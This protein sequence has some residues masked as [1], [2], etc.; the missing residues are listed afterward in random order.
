MDFANSD[1]PQSDRLVRNPLLQRCLSLQ[2]SLDF[3]GEQVKKRLPG[4]LAWATLHLRVASLAFALTLS[5]AQRPGAAG[6]DFRPESLQTL[7]GLVKWFMDMMSLIIGDLFDLA[8]ECRGRTNDLA[9]VR[10]KML[11]SNTPALI[12]TLASAP[13]AFL[14]YNCRSLKGLE[15]STGKALQAGNMVDEDARTT[16]RSF[17]VPIESCAIK[18]SQFE[19]IMTDI[20]GTVRAAYHNV[21]E[22]ERAA[23][24]RVLFVNNEIPAIFAAP[25]ERLLSVTLPQLW[26]E[27]NVSA[28]FF[29]DVSWLGFHDDIETLNYQKKHRVDAVRKVLL[30]PVRLR[31][32][33]RC[34]SIVD[35]AVMS[36]TPVFWLNNF[37]RMCLCGT[38][39][40]H[41][42]SEG[43]DG[44]QGHS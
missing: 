3:Q 20:D 34:C 31:R 24:E 36:K 18:M 9:F 22:A 38:L 29:H 26:K 4:K 40:M 42:P 17:K 7:L 35:E 19:R 15:S 10:Q 44:G 28:L 39:W 33:T 25:V 37:N 32:C 1:A 27:V 41:L 8:N 16:F 5:S 12:L 14:R 6:S 11:E 13:R 30:P 43:G 21:P 23:A 2:F